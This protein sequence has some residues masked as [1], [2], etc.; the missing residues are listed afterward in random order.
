MP[1]S[2]D[3]SA[4]LV[5]LAVFAAIVGLLIVIVPRVM[6]GQQC[7]KCFKRVRRG[8]TKCGQCGTPIVR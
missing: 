6:G 3:G 7:P 4:L 5:Y 2:T 8:E 1:D